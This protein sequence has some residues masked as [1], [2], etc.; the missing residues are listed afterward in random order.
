MLSKDETKTRNA[1]KTI[2]HM[3]TVEAVTAYVAGETRQDVLDAAQ[4]QIDF[5]TRFDTS[6]GSDKSDASHAQSKQGET[7]PLTQKTAEFKGGGVQGTKNPSPS[8]RGQGEGG[9][10]P[11]SVITG[12]DVVDS[13]DKAALKLVNEGAIRTDAAAGAETKT[14]AELRKA[15]GVVTCDDVIERM[16]AEG[17]AI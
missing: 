16:R 6:D 10:I 14:A 9:S 17:K 2:D 15:K 12:H 11:H 13:L 4:V 8:G 1:I 7:G 5:I 3:E